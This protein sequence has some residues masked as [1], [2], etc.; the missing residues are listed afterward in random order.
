MRPRRSRRAVVSAMVV[1][2][3]VA[4]VAT[5][6][7][8]YSVQPI[9][10]L[11]EGG[12]VLVWREDDEPFFNSPDAHC[13]RRIGSVS[14]VCRGLAMGQ[15]PMDRIILRLPYLA[16]AYSLSVGGREFDR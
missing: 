2:A 13:L 3:C 6:L 12:T 14:L 11:P 7:G 8:L 16:W 10:A 1:I 5:F 15:A 9:G 4:F